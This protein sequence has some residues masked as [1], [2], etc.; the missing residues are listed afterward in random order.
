MLFVI[1]LGT[2]ATYG[3]LI[4]AALRLLPSS[5]LWAGEPTEH[6]EEYIL[7]TSDIVK[8][9][10]DSKELSLM[11]GSDIH[12]DKQGRRYIVKSGAENAGCLLIDITKSDKRIGSFAA[13]SDADDS[14]VYLG[15][16]PRQKRETSWVLAGPHGTYCA[17]QIDQLKKSLTDKTEPICPFQLPAG[18]QHG[19]APVIV[20]WLSNKHAILKT[21]YC[22]GSSFYHQVNVASGKI[23][24]LGMSFESS[25]NPKI[26]ALRPWS[27][28]RKDYWI[29]QRANKSPSKWPSEVAL[30][31]CSKLTYF[32]ETGDGA[33]QKIQVKR[34]KL[35]KG[36]QFTIPNTKKPCP[37]G[38]GPW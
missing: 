38:I 20:G 33:V 23:V 32:L 9:L 12:Y 7:S 22:C 25:R 13:P 10:Y 34:R 35:P 27:Q 1:R 29:V 37:A 4:A 8:D 26:P 31:H 5:M 18:I 3:L 15:G 2:Y 17:Y 30:V 36:S 6:P 19:N 24:G 11:K 28:D 16:S 14:C 21:E